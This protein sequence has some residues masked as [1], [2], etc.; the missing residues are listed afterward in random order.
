MFKKHIMLIIILTLFSCKKEKIDYAIVSGKILNTE[1]SLD[2]L[3]QYGTYNIDRI[4]HLNEDGTFKDT[5]RTKEGLYTIFDGK[6][7]IKFYLKPAKEYVIN[8]DANTFRKTGIQLL[9]NDTIYNKYYTKKS[10][11]FVFINPIERTSESEIRKYLNNIRLMELELINSSNLPE[12][13]KLFE[14]EDSYYKYLRDLLICL[15]YAEIESPTQ[16]TI[17]EFEIDYNDEIK[18]RTIPHYYGFVSEHY[19]ILFQDYE[20]QKKLV[21]QSYSRHQNALKL[22]ASEISN[23]YIKNDLITQNAD[24]HMRECNDIREFYKDLD[25]YYKG[26]DTVF[27]NKMRN[28]Y[29]K[30][31][32]L[33]KGETSPEFY[34]YKNY[35]GGLNSLNDY[36]GKYI[37]INVWAT[38]CGPCYGKMEELKK[39]AIDYKN[40]NIVFLNIAYKD[41][42]NEW[43]KVIKDRKLLGVQLLANN[44]DLSFFKEYGIT[45]VPRFILLDEKGK[46]I[47]FNAPSPSSSDN[48]LRKVLNELLI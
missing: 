32:Q 43:R 35:E 7:M 41:K 38:W 5:I 9:G 36:K 30:Y 22:Y 10:Q 34:N 15:Y 25:I 24:F 11:N 39:L 31:S 18:Y 16:E 47:F 3:A 48:E 12:N 29:L 8:Y 44:G 21:D 20:K 23:E 42:E 19:S 4:I 1:K 26:K 46:I 14:R 17:T 37:L 40:K 13:L 28:L 6:N 27:L 33:K 45:G 2:F